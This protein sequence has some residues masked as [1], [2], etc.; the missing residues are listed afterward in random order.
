M[1][2]KTQLEKGSLHPIDGTPADKIILSENENKKQ[3]KNKRAVHRCVKIQKYI[4]KCA[5]FMY[6]RGMVQVKN[7]F[8]VFHH[9]R[10]G[11]RY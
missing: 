7:F 8:H 9:A 3:V 4:E 2:H 5:G 6:N 11:V 10:S 1:N